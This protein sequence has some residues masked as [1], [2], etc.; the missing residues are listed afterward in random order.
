VLFEARR[1]NMLDRM[2]DRDRKAVGG[3]EAIPKA[4]PIAWP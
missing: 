3:P 1:Q 2:E 4:L